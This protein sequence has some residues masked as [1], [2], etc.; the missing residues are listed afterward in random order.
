M[1][2]GEEVHVQRTYIVITHT[3]IN[4]HTHIKHKIEIV[5]PDDGYDLFGW[6]RLIKTPKWIYGGMFITT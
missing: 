5:N 3:Q 6:V 4:I 1:V 2:D